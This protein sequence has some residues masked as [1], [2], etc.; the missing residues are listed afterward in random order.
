MEDSLHP[1]TNLYTILGVDI[2]ASQESIRQQYLKLA[3]TWHPDRHTGPSADPLTAKRRFQEISAAFRVLSNIK[4]RQQYDL[5]LLD[6]LHVEDYLQR[7]Q[8]LILTACG[9]GMSSANGSNFDLDS[10][11]ADTAISN[12]KS[13]SG[14]RH[15]WCLTAA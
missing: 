6:L 10:C 12:S 15:A 4:T 1:S 11:E 2:K 5:G 3:R 7:F 9:L 8:G 13:H 14:P